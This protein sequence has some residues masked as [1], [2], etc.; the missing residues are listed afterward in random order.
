MFCQLCAHKHNSHVSVNYVLMDIFVYW[1]PERDAAVAP[2]RPASL[3]FEATSMDGARLEMTIERGQDGRAG[4]S[5][6]RLPLAELRHLL[7]ERCAPVGEE[8]RAPADAVGCVVARTERSRW[9]LPPAP[10]ALLDG[11]AIAA[12][13]TFA[14][15]PDAPIALDDSH[16]VAIGDTVPAERDAVVPTDMAVTIAGRPMVQTPVAVGENLRRCGEDASA[17]GMVVAANR[18]LSPL[19]ATLAGLAGIESV[20]VRVPRVE[21][22]HGATGA[23]AAHLL[24]GA[25]RRAGAECRVT[26]S[27]PSDG[28]DLTIALGRAAIGR[29]DPALA[30][31]AASAEW[32]AIGRPAMRPGDSIVCGMANGRP[33]IVIPSRLDALLAALLLLVRPLLIALAGSEEP[34]RRE[35]RRLTRKIASAVGISELVLLADAEAGYGWTPIGVGDFDWL[36]S[37]SAQ[38]YEEIPAESEGFGEGE[39]FTATMLAAVGGLWSEA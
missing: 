36:A 13:E 25:V 7:I 16:A 15:S 31:V 2:L 3:S 24:A 1:F 35:T 11:W 29:D 39:S 17:G 33:A 27:P 9:P 23:A 5:N 34:V 10:L 14:A 18:R 4:D 20:A 8:R 6:R 19:A 26:D 22:L 30:R 21:L 38:A 32:R 28:C 37:A 12:A